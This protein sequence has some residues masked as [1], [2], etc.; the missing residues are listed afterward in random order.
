[1]NG[2]SSTVTQRNVVDAAFCRKARGHVYL[3]DP[4]GA[5]AVR[6]MLFKCASAPHRGM[7]SYPAPRQRRQRLA[8]L[9]TKFYERGGLVGSSGISMA[10]QYSHAL[11][12]PFRTQPWR[13]RAIV[14]LP[15]YQD[16]RSRLNQLSRARGIAPALAPVE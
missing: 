5:H 10:A 2:R 14:V 1:L 15:D 11:G 4:D 12:P 7:R 16:Q 6:N 13:R 8:R 9:T 3:R